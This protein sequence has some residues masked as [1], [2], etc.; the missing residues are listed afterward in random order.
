MRR[1]IQ[2]TSPPLS[3]IGGILIMVLVFVY[4]SLDLHTRSST[5]VL[6]TTA[7][8]SSR[9]SLG[10]SGS[11]YTRTKYHKSLSP[12]LELGYLTTAGNNSF[13]ET[14]Q[15]KGVASVRSPVCNLR[16]HKLDISHEDF[17]N[18]VVREFQDHYNIQESVTDPVC[19]P[20]HNLV[21]DELYLGLRFSG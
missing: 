6:T 13:Q 3:N 14:M 15:T 21:T 7:Q 10:P 8:C 2:D 12:D 4:T 1:E 19:L 9:V 17:V 5:N 20:S 16:Q 11:S 18:A